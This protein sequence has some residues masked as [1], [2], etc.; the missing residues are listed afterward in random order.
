MTLGDLISLRERLG[1]RRR[2]KLLIGETYA[3]ALKLAAGIPKGSR[4]FDI[5]AV[6]LW[7]EQHPQWAPSRKRTAQSSAPRSPSRRK[8]RRAKTADK[9]CDSLS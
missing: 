8:G 3:S 1:G 7:K 9:A 5:D 2:K 4:W 6:I